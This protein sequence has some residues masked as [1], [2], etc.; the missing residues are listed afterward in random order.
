MADITV[1]DHGSICVLRGDTDAGKKWIAENLESDEVQ[2]W[3]GGIVVEPRYVGN[4]V[5]GAMIDELE[6][7]F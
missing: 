4:I 1:V 5:A 6:V 7:D 3:G 2:H